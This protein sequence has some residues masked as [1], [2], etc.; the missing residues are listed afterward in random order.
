M[1]IGYF[2][3][4]AIEATLSVGEAGQMAVDIWRGMDAVCVHDMVEIEIPSSIG[5]HLDR[6]AWIWTLHSVTL[7]ASDDEIRTRAIDLAWLGAP[8]LVALHIAAAERVGADHYVTHSEAS[9]SW[10]AIR[11]LNSVLLH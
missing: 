9:A 4:S 10:A 7:V 2:D 3:S 11:G 6:V 1:T 8:P 5:R